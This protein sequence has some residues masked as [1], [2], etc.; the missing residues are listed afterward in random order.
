MIEEA[1]TE[2]DSVLHRADPRAKLLCA[3]AFACAVATTQNF[4]GAG[5]G[6]GVGLLLPLV[7]GIGLRELFRRLIPVNLFLLFLWA[8]VPLTYGGDPLAQWGPLELSR[9]G[10]LLSALVS[11]KAN[12][13]LLAFVCLLTT[14]SVPDLGRGLEALGVPDKLCA[15][16]LFSYRYIFVI[17]E[18][19]QRL[20]RAASMRGFRPSTGKHTYRTYAYLVGMTLVRSHARAQRVRQAMAL[21]CFDGRFRGLRTFQWRAADGVLVGTLAVCSLAVALSPFLSRVAG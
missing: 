12:A 20:R 16:M 13:I 7:A 4:V 5:V 6:L 1:R 9:Q 11:M 15:L 8:V 14:S 17:A 18:E 2:G 21:R 10:V 3:V 19:Y